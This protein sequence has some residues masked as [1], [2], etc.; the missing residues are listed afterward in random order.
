LASEAVRQADKKRHIALPP[1]EPD[2]FDNRGP[3]AFYDWLEQARLHLDGRLLLFTL[4]EFEK[5]EEAIEQGHLEVAV[6]DVL[7][8]LIQHHSSWLVLLF[9]GVRTLEQMSRNWH[10]YFI[11]VRPLRVSYLDADAARRLISLPS[12]FYPI[13]Y[14]NQAVEAIL[15]ATRAQPFLVQAVC[16]ELIQHLNSPR[17]RV[18]GPFGRVTVSD[19]RQAIDR[20]VR[21]AYPYFSDLWANASSSEQLI[22]AK[23]AYGQGGRARFSDLNKSLDMEPQAIHQAVK[24]LEQRELLEREGGEYRFQI[25]MVRRWI[26]D[27]ISLEALRVSSQSLSDV[28]RDRDRE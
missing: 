8:H 26:C 27:E 12:Q 14:D 22:Q 15:K 3:Y 21:R 19:T 18:T 2:D 10:S 7:R 23:L 4:D 11:G 28:V 13:H 6:L 25:P 9:A 5:I 16:F 20:A 24:R 1:V 17:R